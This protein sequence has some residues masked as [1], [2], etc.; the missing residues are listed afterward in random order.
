[1]PRG[2]TATLHMS[3]FLRF[4][5]DQGTAVHVGALA[6]NRVTIRVRPETTYHRLQGQVLHTHFQEL[7][8]IGNVIRGRIERYA[9]HMQSMQEYTWHQ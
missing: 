4:E 9:Q 5:N 2:D 7:N 1:M 6:A 8:P 3:A